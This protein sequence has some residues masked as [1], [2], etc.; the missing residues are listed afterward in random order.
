MS[1]FFKF[2]KER[3]ADAASPAP[4]PPPALKKSESGYMDRMMA[5]RRARL[6]PITGQP[7]SGRYKVRAQLV[8]V[9]EGDVG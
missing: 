8:E 1:G 3:E 7:A 5:A 9:D 6:A 2:P 4:A